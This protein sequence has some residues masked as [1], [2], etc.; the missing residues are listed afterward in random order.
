MEQKES[1]KVAWK[2]TRRG[3]TNIYS[4]PPDCGYKSY[5]ENYDA[6]DW[7]KDDINNPK[8]VKG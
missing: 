2:G 5:G 7:S 3:R 4:F 1:K 8:Y 6:I